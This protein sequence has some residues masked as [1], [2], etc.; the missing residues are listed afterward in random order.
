MGYYDL[1]KEQRVQLYDT[2]KDN[3]SHDIIEN[4]LEY[5]YKYAADKDTY[6]RKNTYL[7]MGRLY[8]TNPPF[9]EIIIRIS[10]KLLTNENEKI[11]Q[12][13]VNCLGEIGKIDARNVLDFFEIAIHDEH[14]SVRNAVIGSLKKMGQVN[15]EPILTFT[16]KFLHHPEPEIRREVIH[17]IE[18]RGRTH[19]EEVLPLLKEVQFEH[20]KRVR[21]MV[22]HVL[23]QI[24]YKEN[25]LEKVIQ[26]L[27][28]WENIAIVEE[29][30]IEILDVHVRY[31]DFSVKTYEQAK[32]YINNHL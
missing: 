21:N 5:I 12:T 32:E 18:L 9:Q 22:I 17:G 23:G 4:K 10:E 1:S 14:H 25:C 2:M 27:S 19:P 3:I 11:R 24:S 20:V 7:I 26:A 28:E 31:K 16:K 8:H 6:I 15:P 30:I 29:A 13:I